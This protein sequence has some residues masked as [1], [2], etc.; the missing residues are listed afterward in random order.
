MKTLMA[1]AFTALSFTAFAQSAYALAPLEERDVNGVTIVVAANGL[2]V[3]TFDADKTT[4]ST[5]YNACEKAWPP[6]VVA[7]AEGI[8]APVGVTTRKDGKI[9][10]TLDGKPVYF[11]IG[12]EAPGDINGDGVG[13]VWHLIK[14]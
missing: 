7:S 2:T 8:Q 3:Y 14:R 10:L 11:Y 5:C 1:L 4:E 9:Q 13:G 6:V 12:D